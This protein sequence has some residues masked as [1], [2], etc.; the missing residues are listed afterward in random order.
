MADDLEVDGEDRPVTSRAGVRPS[1]RKRW[2][3]RSLTVGIA[4][5]ALGG[6]AGIVFYSYDRGRQA[7]GEAIAPVI[8]AQEGPTKVRP[9][10]P[11]GMEVPNQDKQVYGR[12]A[13]ADRPPPVER[14]I[15][16]P[17]A[18]V[19]R[20]P[21]PP[22]ASAPAAGAPV[23][24]LPIPPAAVQPALEPEP[25]PA[26]E[27][28]PVVKA[29]PPKPAAAPAPERRPAAAGTYRV[30]IAALRSDAAAKRA[31]AD[32]VKRHRDLFGELES[33]IVRADLGRKGIYYRLQAGPLPDVAA[34]ETLCNRARQ[35]KLGCI[36]VRP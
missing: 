16:P 26:P 2:I 23:A 34:A 10:Q 36:V 24:P 13:P 11:G 22:G 9:E 7:G 15:A 1:A 18:T 30:Q 28:G 12:I 21:P 29:E 25:K 32:F 6:F 3:R 35:R 8:K 5:I 19:A 4:L 20:P 33:R 27:P 31:W 17:E 14:L